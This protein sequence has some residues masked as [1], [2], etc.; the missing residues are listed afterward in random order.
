MSADMSRE[1]AIVLDATSSAAAGEL[2][3]LLAADG[4]DID[5][6]ESNARVWCF[7]ADEEQAVA[8][9]ERI[10]AL[11][12][13]LARP[14][15]QVPPMLRVWSATHYRY[16][17]PAAPDDDP[18]FRS[19]SIDSDIEPEE[20]RWRVRLELDL[21]FEFRRVRRELPSLRRP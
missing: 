17:D 19:V 15:L 2:A 20:I 9:R 14:M 6:D 13:Q 21:V 5:A 7:A 12:G 4:I 3:E 1:W 8:A 10:R 16:V 18:D 11:V